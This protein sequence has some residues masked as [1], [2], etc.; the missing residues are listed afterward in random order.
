M[1]EKD[2]EAG[3]TMKEKD[4]KRTRTSTRS[5]IDAIKRMNPFLAHSQ[6]F[7]RVREEEE[8]E[9]EEVMLK[10]DCEHEIELDREQHMKGGREEAMEFTEVELTDF[11]LTSSA[12][13][14]E[15]RKRNKYKCWSAQRRWK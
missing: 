2:R 3:R 9:E 11:E 13:A 14:R 10:A 4:M 7:E 12:C 15:R 6:P 5:V 8:E 1:G